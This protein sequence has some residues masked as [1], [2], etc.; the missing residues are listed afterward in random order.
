MTQR[1]SV[2]AAVLAL[3]AASAFA[4]GNAYPA[5][6]IRLLLP[7][8]PGGPSD[9]IARLVANKLGEE[10][11]QPIVVVNAPGAGGMIASQQAAAAA[12]AVQDLLAGHVQ[13]FFDQLFM[14]DPHFKDGKLKP[15]VTTSPTRLPALPDVPT[16]AELG[17]PQL[18]LQSWSGMVAPAG[19]PKEIVAYLN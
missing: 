12:P 1:R 19:T 11:K 4:Q 8:A 2:L 6:P 3:S 14:L 16:M 18:T 17:L 7:F 13:L 9:V 15:L 10:V 5:K